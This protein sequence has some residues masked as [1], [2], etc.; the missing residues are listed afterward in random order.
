MPIG[1]LYVTESAVDHFLYVGQSSRM[2]E[3]SLATYLGSGDYFTRALAEHGEQNFSKTILDFY[4]DQTELDYAEVYTIARLR[5][6]GFH[7][8]NGGVGGPR[9]HG[10]FIRTMFE[11]YRVMP[12]MTD[13]W[14]AAVADNRAEVIEILAA[15]HDTPTD[16]FYRE[17]E[18]QLLQTQDLSGDCPS[19][20]SVAGAVCRT[21]TD[22]PARNHAKRPTQ[23]EGFS[24]AVRR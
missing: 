13:A 7:L 9:A 2:D 8:Y 18:V 14:L 1:Y 20:G 6:E 17:Y 23:T 24:H 4:E 5:A 19:C 15:G 12:R 3:R 21:K 11:H 10:P 22:K 16:D